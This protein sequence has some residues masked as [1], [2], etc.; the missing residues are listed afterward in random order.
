MI[1]KVKSKYMKLQAGVVRQSNCL[2]RKERQMAVK[3]RSLDPLII[4]AAK[5]EFLKAGYERA[6]L[7]QIVK[8]AGITTGALYT[9]YKNKDALFCSLVE[10]AMAEMNERLMPMMKE[11]EQVS[12]SRDLNEFIKVVKKE[13]QISLDLLFA[14]YDECVLFFCKSEGSS[15]GDKIQMMKEMKAKQTVEFFKAISD[16]TCEIDLDG[17]EFIIS[18]QMDYYKGILEKGYT[19]EKAIECMK[20]IEIFVDAGWKAIFAQM[21]K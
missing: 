7:H 18:Q 11:Y 8:K 10:P 21:K 6:S 5:E 14:F 20:T 4:K 2:H 13:E 17:I 12:Q 15:I 1:N 3:D 19:K 9:R 16:D